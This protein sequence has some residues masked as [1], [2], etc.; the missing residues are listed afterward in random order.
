MK[1]LTS[2]IFIFFYFNLMHAQPPQRINIGQNAN[3]KQNLVLSSVA[4]TVR[5]ISLETTENNL[6]EGDILQIELSGNDIF[7][8]DGRFVYKYDKNGK[9]LK[10]IGKQGRGPGEYGKVITNFL[11]DEQAKTITVFDVMKKAFIAYSVDGNFIA[12][13]RTDFVCG[14]MA[15][16]DIDNFLAYNMGFTYEQAGTWYDLFPISKK[17]G[18]KGRGFEFNKLKDRKYGMTIY[19]AIFYSYQ[20]NLV[21]KNP[22]EDVVF[23]IEPKKKTPLYVFDLGRYEQTKDEDDF[24]VDVDKKG[25]VKMVS[26]PASLEKLA[27][28]RLCETDAYLYVTYNMGDQTLT[29]VFDKKQKQFFRIGN[30]KIDGLIDDLANG[31]AFWPKLGIHGKTMVDYRRADEL[32]EELKSSA[33]AQPKSIVNKLNEEDNQ[34]LILAELK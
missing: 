1:S 22:Q 8:C 33:G 26:N 10:K 14:P 2:I 5:Y 7:I 20:N 12:E 34:V 13:Y 30:G 25:N 4:S 21:Y 6:M 3:K 9:F 29:G 15:P 32:K 24:K 17:D 18:K 28:Y 27:V 11:L 31:V 23:K 16:L 19:P